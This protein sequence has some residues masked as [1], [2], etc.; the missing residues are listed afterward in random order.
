M[1]SPLRALWTFL[2]V[3][4]GAVLEGLVVAEDGRAASGYTIH[5][6]A[7]GGTGVAV[8]ATDAGGLYSFRDLSAGSYALGVEHPQGGVAPVVGPPVRLAP[9]QLARRDLKLLSASNQQAQQ[10]IQGN[11]S[12]G[13]WWAGLTSAAKAWSVVAVVVVLGITFAALD[14]DEQPASAD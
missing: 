7:D 4:D 9:G 14:D 8:A 2:T 11:A 5:L 12:L 6:I 1:R 3:A 10:A 13:T